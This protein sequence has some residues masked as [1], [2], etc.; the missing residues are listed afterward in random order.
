MNK[1]VL[2]ATSL[3]FLFAIGCANKEKIESTK[4]EEKA[5]VKVEQEQTIAKSSDA[6]KSI[7]CNVNKDKRVISLDKSPKRC[8]VFYTK[9]GEKS[10]VAWAE[11]T[12][13]IC[14][15][16]MS[17]IRTNIE[18]KGFKCISDAENHL[19]EKTKEKQTVEEKAKT[20]KRDTASEE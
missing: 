13:S 11:A 12:P 19:N 7:T 4:Q 8:E 1:Y 2:I 20:A 5:Q 15:D 9:F 17:K 10:Q 16:V 3:S 18:N 14:T 6:D